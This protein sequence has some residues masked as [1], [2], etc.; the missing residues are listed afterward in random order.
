MRRRIFARGIGVRRRSILV[1]LL[2]LP[3]LFWGGG[4]PGRAAGPWYGSQAAASHDTNGCLSPATA[5]LTIAGAYGKASSGDTIN[6]A[7]G[8]Y[9]E[10]L[11]LNK[12]ITLVGAGQTMTFLDGAGVT[13]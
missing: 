10:H 11:T 4:Q 12:D 6:I 3:L 5:C 8:D 1:A 7:A 2:S 13:N 9:K